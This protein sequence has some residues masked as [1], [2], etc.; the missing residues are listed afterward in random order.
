MIFKC[1]FY[2]FIR[3]VSRGASEII[4]SKL[5]IVKWEEFDFEKMHLLKVYFII[6]LANISLAVQ[7]VLL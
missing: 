1:N 5:C 4:F 2:S 6:H 7:A 3:T